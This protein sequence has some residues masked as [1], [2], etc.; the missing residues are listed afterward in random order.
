MKLTLNFLF[1]LIV[2]ISSSQIIDFPEGSFKYAL[3]NSEVVDLDGDGTVDS[4]IDT[5]N[6][7]EIQVSEAEAVLGINLYNYGIFPSLEGMEHFVNIEWLICSE[8]YTAFVDFSQN[9]K[10]ERITISHNALTNLDVSQNTNLK[11]L[12]CTNNRLVNLNIKNGDN[13]S[14]ELFHALY[15]PD[16]ACIQVDDVAYANNAP[17]WKKDAMAIYS[18]DCELVGIEDFAATDF[19]LFPNP[20]E[21][22]LNIQSKTPIENVKIYS[23]QGVL[24][25]E[26]NS[27][28]IDVSQLST[29]IYFVEITVDDKSVTKKF[30]KN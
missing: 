28:T 29:G 1:L 19:K 9:T 3:I 14:L 22:M 24:V 21:N 11:W 5:N 15:N 25:N 16:L 30:I 20:T 4:N 10:I 6:D 8:S 17:N 7:G 18:E 23:P 26:Y 2:T 27:N 13:T 12:N